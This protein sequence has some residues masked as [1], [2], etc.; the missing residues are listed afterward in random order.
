[1]IKA[2]IVV[3]IGT[4][5]FVRAFASRSAAELFAKTYRYGTEILEEEL[6]KG[7]NE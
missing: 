2:Y 7:P 3:H 1:M 4:Q 6:V 5:S